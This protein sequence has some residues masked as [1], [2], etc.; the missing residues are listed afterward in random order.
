MT[1]E[2][3]TAKLATKFPKIEKAEFEVKDYPTFRVNS[4]EEL[5]PLMQWLKEEAG[6]ALL[7]MVTG[8]DLKGS[9]NLDGFI[10][11]PNPNVFLPEGA[12]PQI[13]PPRDMP[14]VK[15]REM[16][17]ILYAVQNL[18]EKILVMFKLDVPRDGGAA[19]TLSEIYPTADWQERE[20]FDL[21]GVKFTG[22]WNLQKILTPDFIEG[23]PLRKD[24]VHKKDRFDD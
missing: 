24:Y 21:L 6:F 3:F 17:E 8:T 19:P 16:I 7:H 5:L 12:T 13:Q 18:N 4:P 23:Y 14:N 1:Q 2:E 11:E 9:L 22:H 20:I 10:R 15:Y